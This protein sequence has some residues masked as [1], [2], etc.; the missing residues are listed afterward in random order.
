MSQN[1]YIASLLIKKEVELSFVLIVGIRNY[2]D[3]QPA[4]TVDLGES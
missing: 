1:V 4:A 3:S 2:G